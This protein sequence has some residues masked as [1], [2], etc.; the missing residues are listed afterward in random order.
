MDQ[1]A[2]RHEVRRRRRRARPNAAADRPAGASRLGAVVCVVI[3]VA[4]SRACS[5]RWRRGSVAPNGSSRHGPRDPA[6]SRRVASDV[7]PVATLPRAEA[8]RVPGRRVD[9]LADRHRDG[10]RD[11][12]GPDTRGDIAGGRAPRRAASR[13]ERR[14]STTA[15]KSLHRIDHRLEPDR[16]PGAHL[17]PAAVRPHREQRNER[18]TRAC[19]ISRRTSTRMCRCTRRRPT[20]EFVIDQVRVARTI[21]VVIGGALFLIVL[22]IAGVSARRAARA[23]THAGSRSAAPPVRIRAAAGVGALR[24]PRTSV[25]DVV[26]ARVARR[27]TAARRRAA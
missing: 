22:S 20:F 17:P 13:P 23:A 24:Q 11:H 14:A 26:G 3:V 12:E 4:S 21:I 16:D 18:R 2:P 27:R 19:G 8:R 25:Y 15:M 10:L 6:A 9:V 1:V 7:G 5:R